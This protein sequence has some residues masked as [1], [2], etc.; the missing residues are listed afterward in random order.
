MS[1]NDY[2]QFKGR[3]AIRSIFS[4]HDSDIKCSFFKKTY[5][6][7]LSRIIFGF[8]QG[9]VYVPKLSILTCSQNNCF[10]GQLVQ[11]IIIHSFLLISVFVWY[12]LIQIKLDIV[13]KIFGFRQGTIYL[14]KIRLLKHLLGINV[15]LDNS[16]KA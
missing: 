13:S 5:M 16:H 2:T 1:L 7:W 10:G 4:I 3:V 14:P 15:F 11:T 12:A 6:Y 8:R 9:C